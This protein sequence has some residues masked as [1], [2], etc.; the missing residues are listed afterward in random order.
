M[1]CVH[2]REAER[3]SFAYEADSSIGPCESAYEARF[4]RLP[5]PCGTCEACAGVDDDAELG[6][7]CCGRQRGT[8]RCADEWDPALDE[9]A[10]PT[11]AERIEALV[12]SSERRMDPPPV[13]QIGRR[14]GR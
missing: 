8:C 2:W 9:P 14:R 7:A 6:C 5:E 11:V 12:R 3:L 1:V 13:E 4:D 10:T